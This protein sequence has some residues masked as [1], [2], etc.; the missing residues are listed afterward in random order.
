MERE[1]LTPVKGRWLGLKV[2]QTSVQ[3]QESFGQVDEESWSQSRPLEKSPFC[4]QSLAGSSSW[5]YGLDVN[6]VANPEGSIWVTYA[7]P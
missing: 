4:A 3:L 7:P 5:K 6:M 2:S 1:V